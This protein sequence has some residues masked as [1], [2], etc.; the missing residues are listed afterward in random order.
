MLNEYIIDFERINKLTVHE[1]DSRNASN[2][3]ASSQYSITKSILKDYIK[4][5]MD[6]LSPR[7]DPENEKF[8]M[9]VEVLHWNKILISAA[10]IRDHKIDKLI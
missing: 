10:D 4:I 5:Y 7:H 2:P 9:V 1:S 8:Q 3:Y 6:H